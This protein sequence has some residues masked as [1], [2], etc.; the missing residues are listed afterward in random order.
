M[1]N[2]V[3]NLGAVAPGRIER[4]NLFV[5]RLYDFTEMKLPVQVI[6]GESDGPTLFVCAAIHGDEINGVEIIRRL[7]RWHGLKKIRGTL[8]AVPIVN[9]FGYNARSRYLPDRRDLN[10]C[11]PGNSEGSLGS[12]LANLF[13][14]QI[15]LN[16]DYGVDLHTGAIHRRNLPQVRAVMEEPR[17]RVLAESMGAPVLLNS[18]VKDGSL[19]QAAFEEGIP[20]LVFE[21]GEALRFEESV[22]QIGVKG[23]INLMREIGMVD[24]A[25]LKQNVEPIFSPMSFWIRAPQSGTLIKLKRLGLRVQNGE[26]LGFITDPFGSTRVSILAPQA[27]VII[28]SAQL[29][30]VNPGDAVYHL[31]VTEKWDGGSA[32]EIFSEDI[33]DPDLLPY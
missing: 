10:R 23:I 4:H 1:G 31:A 13:M 22:I 20:V 17:C 27:G 16:S 18:K 15:V 12:R 8:I 33:T 3:L 5:A 19:R 21:G 6:R 26:P 9:V 2:R 14:S 30:L 11:F 29:P 7:L 25:P 32:P 24:E 28:G